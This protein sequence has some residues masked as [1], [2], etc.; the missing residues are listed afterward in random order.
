MSH[1]R[2]GPRG[3]GL[4]HSSNCGAARRMHTHWPHTTPMCG[5]SVPVRQKDTEGR[6]LTEMYGYVLAPAVS[7]MS[8]ESHCEKLR[9]PAALGCTCSSSHSAAVHQLLLLGA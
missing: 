6:E 7:P 1:A 8:M 4:S 5:E 3:A 2:D 9:A